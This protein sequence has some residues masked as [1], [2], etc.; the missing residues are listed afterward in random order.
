MS[1]RALI[2]VLVAGSAAVGL[3]FYAPWAGKPAA[4]APKAEARKPLTTSKVT[5]S[6]EP[7]PPF[8]AARVFPNVAF[9]H[10]LLIAR[11]PGT[12]RLFV[13]EREGKLFSVKP[14]PDAKADLFF[15]LPKEFKTL[16]RLPTAK[17][18]HEL[19]GL[20]FHPKF[21][22]N[23]YC[24]VF[25]TLQAK[26][27]K[28][29]K[30]PDGSRLS[31]F[32]VTKTD[33]PRIDPDSEEI[34]L[35]YLQ[36]GHNGGDLHFGPDGY[37]YVT[38]GD[39]ANPNPPDPLGTG[40]DC[41]DLL[42]S[43]LRIDVDRAD[44]GLKYAVPKD[45]PFVGV[46][47]VRPEIW[48]YGYRNPWRMSFDRQTGD[49]WVGD[50]GW[51]LWETVH[52]VEKG[53]NGGWSIVEGR[54]P[55]K[56]SQKIGPTPILPP[57]I[58]LPHTIAA[59]VT[60][61]YVYR[62][63]KF[64]DLVGAYV[65]G[66]WETRRV[67]GARFE[68]GRLKEMPEVMKPSVRVVAFGED[69][70]GELYFLDFD[71]GAMY[72]LERNE[73]A[74]ANSNFPRKLSDT[75]LFTADHAPADGLIAFRPNAP[76]WQDGATAEHY[77]AFPG[78][79]S[80]SLFEKPRP[81]PGQVHWHDFR[82]Q[83]PKDTVLV[84]TL[85]VPAA[86]GR[87]KRVETQ[88]LHHDGEDWRG[89]T[90]AWRDDQTDADLV[91]ADGAEKVLRVADPVHPG[92]AREQVW[93]FHSRTQCLTCHNTWAEYALAFNPA[94]LNGPGAGRHGRPN[95]L[96]RFMA[97]G[98]IRRVAPDDKPLPA[99]DDAEAAKQQSLVDPAHAGDLDR[100]AR[101]YLHANCAHCHRFGGGG[102]GV[103]LELEAFRELKDTHT[104]DAAPRQGDFGLP[105]AKLIAP[106]DP[107]RSVLYYRMAK[108]GR[109]RMPHLGSEHPDPL[110][111][112]L[113]DTWL[114]S[115][116]KAPAAPPPANAAGLP[117]GLKSVGAALPF[118]RAF[119]RPEFGP[120]RGA[121]V[122]AVGKLEPGPVRE[123]FDGYL[124]PDPK[125][126]KLGAAPRPAAILGLAGDAALFFAKEAKCAT[127]HKVGDRGVSVGPDFTAIGKTR[128]KAE[129]LEGLLQPSVRVDPQFAA[130]LVRTKDEKA[131]TGLLV[132]RDEKGV[133]VRDAEN[134]EHAFAAADVESVAPSRLSLMPDGLV[135][136][137]TAQ[138][139]ADVI[140][141][142]A[143]RK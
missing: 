45:N 80:M 8:K 103:V 102:G 44:P 123:L 17:G 95:Q 107:H 133:V 105:D 113:V 49:L 25:Y 22:Q 118:A 75:G 34:L 11:C 69:N 67:W 139:A 12:D 26:D 86:D 56:T 40:Q 134:K 14:G 18:L 88:L 48:S 99:W 36:G 142:L 7:P 71:T 109:G 128:T 10:P 9:K 59:S 27:P 100:R 57:A 119:P 29:H 15:D 20:A 101:S 54:Q 13:G 78:A 94:Q 50:V 68:N 42:S 61:G 141:Y 5:G 38:T 79:G 98:I 55:I 62:G 1:A 140:E 125:G 126:R 111:L 47:D 137:W 72:T 28:V 6:P 52:K 129:L 53:S 84:K 92:G 3:A 104:L 19:Y 37:L 43:I 120:S 121:V 41:T 2:G 82:T 63:K 64:P 66:D 114:R 108:F 85:S 116:G 76:Q 124:P 135:A 46:K 83:F 70:A 130:Y 131:V 33:P 90:Y 112:D 60:G 16:D 106:G 81:L 77:A 136:G 93:T 115:L 73:A 143:T 31:R 117:D 138:E 122:A 51:E 132:R 30:L 24:Y 89:Y 4:D 65:F 32:T 35:T 74:G 91:P 21:E 110:A 97:E 87:A 39:A 23:R 127:C 96:V 58:E